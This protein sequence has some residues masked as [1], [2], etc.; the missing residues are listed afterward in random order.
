MGDEGS[1]KTYQAVTVAAREAIKQGR[2]VYTNIPKVDSDLIIADIKKHDYPNITDFENI[3]FGTVEYFRSHDIHDNPNFYPDLSDRTFTKM[4]D[5]D[6]SKYQVQPGDLLLFDEVFEIYHKSERN[7]FT[8]YHETFFRKHR[9]YVNEETGLTTEIIF[10]TQDKDACNKDVFS[11]VT[12]TYIATKKE[13]IGQPDR[14]NVDIY[15]KTPKYRDKPIRTL[16]LQKFDPQKFAW[17]SSHGA[18]GA[19]QKSVDTRQNVLTKGKLIMALSLPLVF[20]LACFFAYKTLVKDKTE[21]N[22]ETSQ[23][24]LKNTNQQQQYTNTNNAQIETEYYVSGHVSN[25]NDHIFYLSNGIITKAL[26][27]PNFHK[28]SRTYNVEFNNK[29]YTNYSYSQFLQQHQQ[30]QTLLK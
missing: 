8:L 13:E 29:W 22:P 26:I 3:K 20:I 30:S 2:R 25:G 15:K 5:L 1:G 16:V 24:D 6:L 10:M 4:S 9:K 12:F 19:V 7:R 11:T 21:T 27:N 14:Y 23:N 17:Y 18:E 28:I